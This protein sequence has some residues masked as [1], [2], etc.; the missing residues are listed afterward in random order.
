MKLTRSCKAKEESRASFGQH[1]ALRSVQS[2]LLQDERLLAFH[3]DIY[4]VSQPERTVE[5]HDNLRE[6]LWDYSRI[7]IHAGKTQI[8]N[9]GEHIPTNHDT[10]L[11]LPRLRIQRRRFGSATMKLSRRG[12]D[13]SSGGLIWELP[14][15][16]GHGF[17]LRMNTIGCFFSGFATRVRRS[18][19][20][21]ARHRGVGMSGHASR[22]HSTPVIMGVGQ[23]SDA[24]GVIGPS[25]CGPRCLRG[26]LG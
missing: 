25:Q 21:T 11:R 7:Q 1:Q 26:T 17:S 15:S 9:R 19:W 5:I 24:H 14:P 18:F 8:W 20:Q 3:D 16:S 6:D 13:Q 2:Q 12:R 4:V 23:S 10:L 22:S